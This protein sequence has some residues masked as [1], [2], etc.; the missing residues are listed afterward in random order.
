MART[1]QRPSARA[2]E[3]WKYRSAEERYA[4]YKDPQARYGDVIRVGPNTV[5][6]LDPAAVPAIYGV[7]ARLDKGPAYIPFRQSRENRSLLTIPDEATHSKYRRL[8]SN[9]YSMSSMKGYEPYVDEIL[10]R[11]VEVLDMYAKTKERMNLSRWCHY[12]GFRNRSILVIREITDVRF[13]LT[14]ML[15]LLRCRLQSHVWQS[16]G[17]S[18]RMGCTWAHCT[19]AG[20]LYVF[21]PRVTDT[22]DAQS[23]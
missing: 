16:T 13:R 23:T 15:R 11:Y 22:M 9:A 14:I 20:S 17:L 10:D 6:A 21:C 3:A 5:V 7:R 1:V 19:C 8:V 2:Y 18:R 12:C 4:F